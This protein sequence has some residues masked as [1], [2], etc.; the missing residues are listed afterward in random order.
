MCHCLYRQSCSML[1][2]LLLWDLWPF[3]CRAAY[4]QVV[5]GH[6]LG[7][8][9]VPKACSGLSATA[10]PCQC[11]GAPG[12]SA[13]TLQHPSVR[14]TPLVH[15]TARA[16]RREA[17]SCLL[18]AAL[19]ASSVSSGV[20]HGLGTAVLGAAPPVRVSEGNHGGSAC[21]GVDPARV[22]W[23]GLGAS[24]GSAQLV[25]ALP[26]L[27]WWEPLPWEHP[28]IPKASFP[29][30]QSWE[31]RSRERRGCSRTGGRESCLITRLCQQWVEGDGA[32]PLP[33]GRVGARGSRGR[34]PALGSPVDGA[35]RAPPELPV[36]GRGRAV[37]PSPAPVPQHH[38]PAAARRCLRSGPAAAIPG[39]VPAQSRG[40]AGPAFVRPAE[41]SGGTEGP[42]QGALSGC[43]HPPGPAPA[44]AA[45][46]ERPGRGTELPRGDLTLAAPFP[47]PG[48]S[49]TQG[50]RAPCWRLPVSSDTAAARGCTGLCKGSAGE[51]LAGLHCI[52]RAGSRMGLC[53]TSSGQP[54][55]GDQTRSCGGIPVGWSCH[56]PLQ[57]HIIC[58]QARCQ[59]SPPA[60]EGTE[61]MVLSPV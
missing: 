4:V 36:P 26:A 31:R 58:S 39:T 15:F 34:G 2:L 29:E 33:H 9:P 37:P 13:V 49:S 53:S 16:V 23:G 59:I 50:D 8:L 11:F 43:Q 19:P 18:Q 6:R 20:G 12:D 32:R 1:Q 27:L 30:H 54:C 17:R 47:G 28:P 38:L 55:A 22:C 44:R 41:P 56:G 48:F 21:R 14:W 35:P 60:G 45:L 24:W 25:T 46:P 57:H 5:A 3:S 42:G 10:A 51:Q 61:E 40:A 52:T 7:L